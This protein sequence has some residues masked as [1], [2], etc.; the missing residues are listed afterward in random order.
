MHCRGTSNKIKPSLFKAAHRRPLLGGDGDLIN[1]GTKSAG[2]CSAAQC[3]PVAPRGS[4][5]LCW[6]TYTFLPSV[7]LV[8]LS[9][10]YLN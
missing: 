6:H 5:H 8:G 1:G 4:R 2:L 7:S 9:Y 10:V 3:H